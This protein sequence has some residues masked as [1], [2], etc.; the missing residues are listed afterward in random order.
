MGYCAH[1]GWDGQALELP[2]RD[3][4]GGPGAVTWADWVAALDAVI[5]G[6]AAPPIL[7]GHDVG[8][9]LAFACAGRGVRAVIAVAPASCGEPPPAAG[10]LGTRLAAWRGR[11]LQPPSGELLARY[12]AVPAGGFVPD[13]ARVARVVSAAGWMPPVPQVPGLVIAAADDRWVPPAAAERLA[14]GLGVAFHRLP[15]THALPWEPGWERL[16]AVAHRW[17]VQTIGEPL[18]LPPEDAAPE[19]C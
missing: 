3:G 18:L 13:S 8:A 12:G 1:R 6:T 11:A 10:G 15:G 4:A 17:L 2:G 9:L 16:V 7:V 14:A 5:A 19:P